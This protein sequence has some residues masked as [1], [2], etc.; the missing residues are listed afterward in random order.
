VTTAAAGCPLCGSAAV[1]PLPP[2]RAGR[3][4]EC[5]ACGLVHRPAEERPSAAGE[6]T[7]YATHRNDPGD[8]R[9][10]A[11][12]DRLA[13][14]LAARLRP[15]AEGLDYGCGPGPALAA[16]LEERGFRMR[17]FDPF[18]APDAGALELTYDFVTCTETVE[19]FHRPAGEFARLDGLLRPGGILA[20]MTEPVPEDRPLGEW[21]YAR[22]PTHVCLYRPRTMEWIARW[23]GWRLESP[24]RGVYLFG[25]GGG[26]ASPV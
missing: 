17:L 21:R 25:K 26:G 14:P 4:L 13:A 2:V 22:D 15:G 6:R 10:R 8:E 16:M 20:V 24:G 18:F 1:H 12:L 11:F 7:H 19:H 23:C 9:Y 3:F 5:S